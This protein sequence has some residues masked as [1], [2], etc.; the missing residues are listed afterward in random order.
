M[1]SY[2]ANNRIILRRR[3]YVRKAGSRDYWFDFSYN[4]LQSFLNR[5]GDDFCLIIYASEDL[6]DAYI[7]PY[8][9]ARNVFVEDL[10]DERGRWNGHINKDVLHVS[11]RLS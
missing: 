1:S 5:F 10:L 9:A 7:I 2:I 3:H 11:H 4:S 6:D 8:Q